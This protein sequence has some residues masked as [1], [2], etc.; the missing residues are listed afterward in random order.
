MFHNQTEG[1]KCSL[2]AV[3]IPSDLLSGML[4]AN[5]KVFRESVARNR[6]DL[7]IGTL[8]YRVVVLFARPTEVLSALEAVD[9]SV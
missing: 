4:I 8:L 2:A 5:K 1:T 6:D 9:E 3:A 7:V